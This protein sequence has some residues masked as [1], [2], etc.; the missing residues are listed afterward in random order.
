MK[1]FENVVL[2][3]EAN[4][5]YDGKVTSRTLFFPDGERMTLGIMLP[6]TYTFSTNYKEVMEIVKGC[7][8]VKLPG[9]TEFVTFGTGE[10]FEVPKQSSFEIIVNEVSDYCCS[11]VKE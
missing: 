1:Q 6:G 3:K 10:V 2:M 7:I 11:Y 4:V 5:Y 8:D 9:E